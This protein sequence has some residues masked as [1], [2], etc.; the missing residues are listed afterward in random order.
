MVNGHPDEATNDRDS[1]E[2]LIRSAGKYVRPS[3]DLRPRT[4]EAARQHCSDRRAERKFGQICLIILLFVAV[5]VP[6]S[7]HA[8]RLRL[9]TLMPTAAEIQTQSVELW[10][11]VGVNWGLAEAV[12]QLRQRQADSLRKNRSSQ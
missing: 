2:S 10:D 5:A 8:D 4:L 6:A 1:I 7:Q 9:N 12:S 11:D 3:D